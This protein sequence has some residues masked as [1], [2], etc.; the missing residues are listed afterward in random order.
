M[1]KAVII[2]YSAT[3]NTQMIADTIDE[4]LNDVNQAHSMY[5]ISETSV[6][7]V[8]DSDIF[9]L[10][11]PAMGVEEIEEYEYR[12][13]FDELKPSLENKPV[14]LFGSFD[15]GDGEWMETWAQEVTEAGGIVSGKF[16]VMLTPEDDFLEEVKTS[17][18]DLMKTFQ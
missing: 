13:F 3:G 1:E 10:G 2:Y 7:E 11:C 5:F 6:D 12:P 14:V 16:T 17:V 4:A 18:T 15:W 8:K 9:F